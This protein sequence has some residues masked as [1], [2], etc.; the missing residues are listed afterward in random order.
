[1]SNF[2][3]KTH[4][5]LT[6]PT[7][8]VILCEVGAR[9]AIGFNAL[10]SAAAVRC[11][12]SGVGVHPAF[13]DKADEPMAFA[14][15]AALD[16][17]LVVT[18]R[19][20]Q[21]LMSAISEALEAVV[22]SEDRARIVCWV[23]LP[24]PR[25]GLPTDTALSISAAVSNAFGFSAVH[26]LQNGH[27][28]GLMALQ[29]AAQKISSGEADI[30]IA[31]GVDSY[32]VPD[33]LD[34]LD[35]NGWLM[36]STNRNGFPPGEAAGACLLASRSTAQH[37]NLPMAATLLAAS[38]TVEPHTIRSTEICIG[39]GLSAGLRAIA[40]SLKFPHE[41]IT[42][43]Y[44]DLN[45]QRYR[46]E[47]FVY[48]L[49]REQVAYVDAHDYLCPADCWGDVGAASGPL[50]A[51]LAVVAMRRGYSK[52]PRPVLWASSG[53]GYRTAVLLNLAQH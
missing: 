24:E 25:P 51:A 39:E 46:N 35:S 29:V 10:A 36:S 19:M 11:G 6:G 14:A 37:L 31:A 33:T 43:I 50:F 12:I 26:T 52:G 2:P 34:W 32:L 7:Q 13:I 30:C 47:E 41:K 44:C 4:S 22:A 8:D 20:E 1:M 23:G 53:S 15:D 45:G 48:T 17:G 28:A 21:M 3:I 40:S 38:T 9:T 18:K 27:A 16:A 49:L 5:W 42:A